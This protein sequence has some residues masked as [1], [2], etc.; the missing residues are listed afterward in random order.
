MLIQIAVFA[1]IFLYERR[2]PAGLGGILLVSV[3]VLLPQTAGGLARTRGPRR[4]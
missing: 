1:W 2:G 4:V 3:G